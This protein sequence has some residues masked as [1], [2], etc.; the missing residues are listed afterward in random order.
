M[1]LV[2]RKIKIVF[3]VQTNRTITQIRNYLTNTIYPGW[4]TRLNTAFSGYVSGAPTIQSESTNHI[5][6]VPGTT[7]RYQVYPKFM[8]QLEVPTGTGADAQNRFETFIEDVRVWT[9]DQLALLTGTTVIS[10]HYHK[11][12]E[13]TSGDITF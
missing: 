8:L 3:T 11:A 9:R 6:L 5:F 4:R 2:Q 7:N 12:D 13:T 1:V 10:L